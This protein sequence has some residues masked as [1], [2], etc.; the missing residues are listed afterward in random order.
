MATQKTLKIVAV[1]FM[2]TVFISFL[3]NKK[4]NTLQHI[5]SLLNG[6]PNG[7]MLLVP[8][9]NSDSKKSIFPRTLQPNRSD[10]L[11][12]IVS[13]SGLNCE[14]NPA[15]VVRDARRMEQSMSSLPVRN[16]SKSAKTLKFAYA[17]YATEN[18]Y[19]CSALAAMSHLKHIR[20][21]ASVPKRN[22][23][24]IT[25]SV[26]YILIYATEDYSQHG[27]R[28]TKSLFQRWEI[29]GTRLQS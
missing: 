27:S 19:L 28:L 23:T 1:L 15:M 9:A 22:K 14:E 25:Y 6:R 29:L 26:D 20:D 4:S 16:L 21:H 3:Y 24:S 5:D 8:S 11:R 13:G 7:L 17:W 10:T 18:D 12:Y 2:Y